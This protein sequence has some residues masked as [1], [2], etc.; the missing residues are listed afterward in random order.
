MLSTSKVAERLGVSAQ[1]VRRHIEAG[2]LDAQLTAGGQ[3]RVSEEA[4]R[5]FQQRTNPSRVPAYQV[6]AVANQKGGVGKTTSVAALGAA[7]ADQGGRVLLVDWDPQA[8]LTRA[9]AQQPKPVLYQALKGYLD[10]DGAAA[11]ALQPLVLA[12]G[13]HLLPGHLDLAAAEM[14]LVVAE[15]REHLLTALLAPLL[16]LYDIILIDC[17]PTLGLLTINALVAADGVLIPVPPET[18]AA[19]GLLLL[20]QTIT[21]LRRRLNP[22]IGVVG[23]LPT[24]TTKT[25]H[26]QAVLGQIQT[27]AAQS[28]LPLLP[29]I[30]RTIKASEAAGAGV[31][32]TRFPGADGIA[33]LYTQLAGR[34]LGQEESVDG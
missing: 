31:A 1:T 25:N 8:N 22:H 13:E 14:L 10:S 30:P 33:D 17:P 3:H 21:R 2:L 26:H 32:I 7:I 19:E 24:M 5:A 9:L 6:I 29:S 18:L 16:P 11:P 28:G 4:L 20:G 27:W 12:G 23:V 15:S 34:L